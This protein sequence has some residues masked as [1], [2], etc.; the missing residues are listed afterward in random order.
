M[1]FKWPREWIKWMPLLENMLQSTVRNRKGLLTK[2][3]PNMVWYLI[4]QNKINTSWKMLKI[5]IFSR[6]IDKNWSN[7]SIFM[8]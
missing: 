3:Q 7:Y 1:M 4:S 2:V 5:K 8:W 6:S